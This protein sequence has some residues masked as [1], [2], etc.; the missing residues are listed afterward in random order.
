M[1][2][3]YFQWMNGILVF[4]VDAD[5]IAFTYQTNP[6]QETKWCHLIGFF[7]NIKKNKLNSTLIENL[8]IN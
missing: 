5:K 4:P 7:L 3:W 2:F 6:H 8:A 1:G